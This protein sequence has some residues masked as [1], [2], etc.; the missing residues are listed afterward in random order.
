MSIGC[1]ALD[2]D[3][4]TLNEFGQLSEGTCRALKRAIGKGVHIVIASGRTFTS[5]PE[6]V[7][8]IPGIEYA[9]TSNGAAIYH[10]PSGRCLHR[11]LLTPR[12]VEQVM[13]L[14]AGEDVTYEAFVEG[15]AHAD[16][17]YV[18]DP[19]AYGADAL[20]AAYVRRTRCPE[21]DIV[22]FLR[23]HIRELDGM[24]I[25][26]RDHTEK[27]R[28]WRMLE[29]EVPELYVTSSIE[30]LL[31]LAHRDAGKHSGLRFVLEQLGISR[32]ETAA[33]GDGD[34]DAQ[35]LAFAGTGIAVANATPACLAAADM[36][37]KSNRE[38]GV[39]YAM[40][41]FLGI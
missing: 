29:R 11:Y 18:E 25:V 8:A 23:D 28:L 21:P 5:L 9:V 37:T 20:A 22:T 17:T 7:L 16:R 10:V 36:V 39:A 38:D 27:A 15:Q 19:A 14:T 34:N 26:L 13:A 1:I 41:C 31:E 30:R 12:S 40:E 32:Q 4:T 35:M 24:D 33:F 2:M 6:D 3:Q